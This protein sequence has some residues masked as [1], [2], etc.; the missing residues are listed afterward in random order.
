MLTPAANG[1]ALLLLILS[2][3]IA[4][5]NA[6]GPVVG[7]PVLSAGPKTYRVGP[8]KVIV[9]PSAVS[10][11]STTVEIYTARLGRTEVLQWSATA[12]LDGGNGTFVGLAG[13]DFTVTEH[14][15]A[16]RV[17][18]KAKNRTRGQTIDAVQQ[19]NFGLTL[20][21]SGRLF[22]DTGLFRSRKLLVATYVLQ[23]SYNPKISRRALGFKV[24][25]D[26]VNPAYNRLY[27]SWDAADAGENFYGFGEQCRW[28]RL[29][30]LA[31]PAFWSATAPHSV[32][33]SLLYTT[34]STWKQTR[35]TGCEEGPF[36]SSP[37]SRA[38]VAGCSRFPL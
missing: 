25:V 29:F 27:V 14:S 18:G 11:L 7:T 30:C 1:V 20:Q 16:F 31:L 6:F 15:G 32:T 2:C 38:L 24:T 8:F 28:S 12:A 37:P 10:N 17:S 26:N 34:S 5:S 36:P 9:A 21:L 19:S 13:G 35:S 23:L 22:A 3:S 4:C 33:N